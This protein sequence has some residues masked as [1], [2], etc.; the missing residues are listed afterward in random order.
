MKGFAGVRFFALLDFIVTAPLAV[1][2]V[3]QR[4]IETLVSAGGLLPV[5]DAWTTIAPS[6]LLF[7][8]LLGVLGACWNG[9]RLQWAD[10]R[11]LVAIDAVARI[12]VSAIL[13]VRIT[14][15]AP[16]ALGV[17]TLTELLGAIVA[18]FALRRRSSRSW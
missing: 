6:T 1:P 9:A 11:R 14:H 4:W 12:A 18:V 13:L 3:T 8:Q 15:A 10:D 5:P 2:G 17:F 16:P 7:A